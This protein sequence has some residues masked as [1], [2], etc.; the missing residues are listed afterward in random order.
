M[1]NGI[2]LEALQADTLTSIYGAAL[3]P[4][5]WNEV[6]DRC[7]SDTG[8]CGGAF[9][10]FDTQ[11]QATYSVSAIGKNV[12]DRAQ[13]N[14]EMILEFLTDIAPLEMIAHEHMRQ[15]PAR[16]VWDEGEFWPDPTAECATKHHEWMVKNL[17]VKH[18]LVARLNDNPRINDVFVLHYLN[19]NSVPGKA[20]PA[21]NSLLPHLAKSAEMSVLYNQLQ[22]RYAAALTVLDKVG[23]GLC[24][25]DSSNR[26]IVSNIEANRILDANY[27]LRL[28]NNAQLAC[29][30]NNDMAQLVNAIDAAQLHSGV[31]R[32][33]ALLALRTSPTADPL[34][35]E[36]SPLRDR[37]DELNYGVDG[38][39]VQLVDTGSRSH[40][41][42][43]AFA[44]AYSLT[45]AEQTVTEHLLD[46]LTNREIAEERG[47][48]ADTVKSQVSYIMQKTNTTSRVE[49]VRRVLKTQPPISE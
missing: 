27:G 23:V 13:T 14:P 30:N 12:R 42:V 28:G 36:V 1:R 40:C 4:I 43:D 48:K 45:K 44:M 38:V 22:R 24:V 26:V 31:V 32:A 7:A 8:A 25:L 21:L 2:S 34:L 47:T 20:I 35:V 3:S 5:D 17:D 41:A 6:I 33:E 19:E 11:D 46:G 39:L 37:L 49:L 18:K 29:T 15:F 9:L 16:K 10:S